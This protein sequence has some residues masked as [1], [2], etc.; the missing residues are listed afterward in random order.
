ML[1][2]GGHYASF[3]TVFSV[4]NN[5]TEVVSQ[6]PRLPTTADF[7]FLKHSSQTSPRDYR[8]RPYYVVQAL[9]WLLRNNFL[10]QGKVHLETL[11]NDP[12]W[13]PADHELYA[14]VPYIDTVPEDYEGMPEPSEQGTAANPGAP[15]MPTQE[16]HLEV[17]DEGRSLHN[18]HS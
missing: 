12:T 15:T 13:N 10:Y 2:Q 3:P 16:V 5:L 18:H 11:A 14:D 1:P 6:L 9:K 17:P 4:F 7:A 8:Y